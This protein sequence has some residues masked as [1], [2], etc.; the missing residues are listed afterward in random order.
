MT[1]PE[2]IRQILAFQPAEV[3]RLHAA[4]VNSTFIEVL[5][6]F[7]CGRDFVRAEGWRVWDDQ[8]REYLDFLAGYGAVSIGHNHPDVR[9]AV[10]EVLRAT[11]PHFLLVSPQPLAA[12]L[13]RRLAVLAPG[14]LDVC[15]LASSGSEAVEGALKLARL[16]TGRPRFVSAEA[17]YHGTTL[18]ALSVTGSDRHRTPF[19]PLLPGCARVRWG[20]VASVERELR[21]RDV[22]AVILEPLQGEGGVRPAPAGFLREVSQLCRRYGTLLVLDEVQTG[23]GRCGR[24][25]ACEEESVEPDVLLLAK[26]LS[27]GLAPI[28][29]LITRRRIWQKAYGSLATYDLH[30]STFSGGPV[31]C[32]AALATLEVIQRDGLVGRAAELGR[33]LGEQIGAVTAGHPL[34]RDVRGKGLF[35]GIELAAPSGVAADLVGQWLV[36]GLIER[37]VLTQVCSE[38]THVVRAQPPLTVTREAIDGYVSALSATLA[39]HAK[40]VFGS[41]VGAAGRAARSLLTG[42]WGGSKD[43]NE[44][45]PPHSR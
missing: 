27:G 11:V 43:A 2:L 19:E 36:A 6:L 24:L 5:S 26:G 37:G 3:R 9:A 17:S 44:T 15:F 33:Y 1:G 12:E 10:E 29:A 40:G 16:A 30:C 18:G 28:S 38:A 42:R 22:A 35:W 45:A 39:E 13:A 31:A 21:R 34:V 4:H 8:G 25:F 20:D 14:D 7:G 32:A 23:L 41:V